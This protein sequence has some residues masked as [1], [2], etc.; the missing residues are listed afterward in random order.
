[1]SIKGRVW[2]I[3]VVAVILLGYPLAAWVIG[4]SVEKQIEAREQQTLQAVPYLTVVN[5]TYR[6]G[7]YAATEEVTYGLSSTFAKALQAAPADALL[8]DA[9]ITIRN[10]IHHGPLPGMRTFALATIDSEPVL[11][12]QWRKQLDKPLGGKPILSSHAAL[13][14]G[15]STHYEV[16]SPAFE[17]ELS[18]GTTVAWQGL[19]GSGDATRNQETS[20][21]DILF[22]GL[23]FR[24]DKGS[25]EIGQIHATTDLHRVFTTLMAGKVGATIDKIEIHPIGQQPAAS[26][27]Q[28]RLEADSAATGDYLDSKFDIS[29][30]RMS[31]GGFEATQLG[32]AGALD[33]EYGPAI[34]A[35]TEKIR[36]VSQHNAQSAAGLQAN[37]QEI[38]DILQHEGVELLVH[39][40]VLTISRIGFVTPEG[41]MRIAAKFTTSGLTRDD[42]SRAGPAMM[43]AVIPHIQATAD[44]AIDVPLLAKLTAGN[45]RGEQLQTQLQ[46]LQKQ[47]YVLSNDKTLTAHMA[48][49]GGRLTVNDM[50]FPP[51]PSARAPAEGA[52]PPPTRRR[53]HG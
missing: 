47:G 45:P 36:A 14:W 18:P 15:G 52:A 20:H 9:R 39:D 34:A 21:A 26:L 28:L 30:G 31:A 6:R 27:Q 37:P 19:S 44:L 40:L 23:Q 48:F 17:M 35:L 3:A 22:K 50:P 10:T 2:V 49:T 42:F 12:A 53:K 41:E 16:V 5:R 11:P 51:P 7:V 4:I 25:G 38:L 8:R 13:S 33:H 46:T 32:Y 29:I 1:M 24:G 43:A